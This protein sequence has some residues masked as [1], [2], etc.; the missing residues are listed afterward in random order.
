MQIKDAV[1]LVTGANRGIGLELV[2][3]LF[4]AGAG[5]V[6]AGGRKLDSLDA[7]QSLDRKRVIPILVDVTNDQMVQNVSKAAPD[8]T[9]LMNNAGFW[10]SAASSMRPLTPFGA[11]SKPTSTAS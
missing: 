4:D 7:V 3:A 11:I 9:I 10:I 1:A 8:V 2:K 6:Y 5:K